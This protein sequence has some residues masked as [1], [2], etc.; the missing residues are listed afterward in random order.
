LYLILLKY[1][2]QQAIFSSTQT[3]THKSLFYKMKYTYFLSSAFCF[4]VLLSSC[5]KN[6]E[7]A[8]DVALAENKTAIRNYITAQKLLGFTETES[9]LNYRFTVKNNTGTKPN[10][11]NQLTIHYKIFRIKDGIVV[12]SSDITKGREKP[13]MV[14]FTGKTLLLGMEEAFEF[15]KKG[16]RIQLLMP[17]NLAYGAVTNPA[18]PANSAIGVDLELVNVRT[19]K[20]Q[21]NDYIAKRIASLKDTAFIKTIVIDSSSSGLKI[22]KTTRTTRPFLA[23]GKVVRLFYVGRLMDGSEFGVGEYSFVL[24]SGTTVKGFEEGIREMRGGERA[25]L[26]FPSSIGYGLEGYGSTIPPYA[27]LSFEVEIL[28]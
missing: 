25:L 27:P 8:A 7:T 3:N 5:S 14:A 21:I 20:Q 15:M 2:K 28:E 23:N 13:L 10:I 17:S 26:V 19:E 9:G 1:T 16:E 11:G 22:I 18:V 6:I 4:V 24:G 12:D